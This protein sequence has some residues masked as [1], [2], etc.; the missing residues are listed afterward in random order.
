MTVNDVNTNV[1]PP[2][3]L[4]NT[5]SL[6]KLLPRVY[7]ELRR[8]AAYHLRNERANHTLTPTEIVHEVYMLLRKQHSLDLRDRK[9]FFAIASSIIRRLLVN[10]ARSRKRMKRGGGKLVELTE[11]IKD[12]TL[13]EFEKKT[14]DIIALERA[15]VKL[16]NRDEQL[17]RIVELRYFGGLTGEE[18]AELLEISK[19]TVDRHWVFA[20]NW[21]YRELMV[22]APK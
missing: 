21:L 13:V 7:S 17:V 2:K 4:W 18:T 3:S 22:Q 14:I 1:T 15:L 12:V 11:D 20:K 10:Y 19:S 9:Y 6:D 8:L 5:D 16:G